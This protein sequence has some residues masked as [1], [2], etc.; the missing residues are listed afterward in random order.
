MPSDRKLQIHARLRPVWAAALAL[1]CVSV[2]AAAGGDDW[3]Y[4]SR[5][6]KGSW[7]KTRVTSETLDASGNVTGRNVTENEITL[8]DR[9]ERL[10]TLRVATTV[11]VAGKRFN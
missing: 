2:S 3:R 4:W 5:F 8:V 6:G 11:H 9:T 7:Q 1:V 10:L